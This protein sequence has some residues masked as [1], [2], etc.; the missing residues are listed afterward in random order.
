[1]D[2]SH[3]RQCGRRVACAILLVAC[4]LV[5][6]Q[7]PLRPR[8]VE[9]TTVTLMLLDVVVTDHDGHPVRGLSRKDFR[10]RLDGKD[11]SVESV[12]DLCPCGDS[13]GLPAGVASASGISSSRGI[14][15]ASDSSSVAPAPA[16]PMEPAQFILYLDFIQLQ[17]NGRD[18]SI[19]AARQWVEEVMKPGDRVMIVGHASAVG[20][21]VIAPFTTDRAALRAAL[22]KTAADRAFVDPFPS[23]LLARQEECRRPDTA[24]LCGTS[25]Q[26]VEFIGSH[27]VEE[28]HYG[29]R[30][31]ESL[32][33]FL[34]GLESVPGRK[35]LILFMQN[36]TIYPASLYARQGADLE[37]RVDDVIAEATMS[38]VA[39][40]AA[41]NSGA[42][43]GLGI[44]LAEGTGG[45][46]NKLP[47]VISPMMEEARDRCA[48]IYRLGLQP[49]AAESRKLHRVTVLVRGRA[50]PQTFITQSL[51]AIDRWL[52]S[53]RAVL[54]NPSAADDLPVVAGIIPTGAAGGGWSAR[55]Q[56]GF[57]LG[58]LSMLPSGKDHQGGTWEVGA[59]LARIGGGESWEML[60]VSTIRRT[61]GSL[62]SL[63]VVH[64]RMFEHLRH[65]E[66]RLAAFVRD[67]TGNVF[68]GA[69]A[70]I[71]LPKPDR[72]VL[73]GPVLMRPQRAQIVSTLPL[74]EEAGKNKPSS[75][76]ST[77]IEASI[78]AGHSALPDELLEVSTWLCGRAAQAPAGRLL[79]FVAQEETPILEFPEAKLQPAGQC[80]RI[81][82]LIDRWQSAAG[83]YTY[84]L[85]VLSEDGSEIATASV[86]IEI[87]AP[88]AREAPAESTP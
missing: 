30:S 62:T 10:V 55:V 69:E 81:T 34:A 75:R 50:L 5:P 79:R 80:S 67:T 1:M 46:Y 38:R 37:R 19:K 7:E 49:P 87:S 21:R 41:I 18:S 61:P 84:Y 71:V 3:A 13:A 17:T 88:P 53:A 36:G 72:S 6:A 42:S 33:D 68:G 39:I 58:S 60:G 57:D 76:G 35:Q 27:P 78:S 48:C 40:N 22:E 70:T 25:V 43:M 2:G 20:L 51:P 73:A 82:D 54:M 86:P 45:F 64:E 28:Y 52:R 31:L 26:G 32:R 44:R 77:V 16:L 24:Y 65:G 8:G 11:W 63:W 83:S 47:G 9:T 59:A 74:L 23:F 14:P 15:S 56:V 4:G 85:R 29:R 12:D 66:Y